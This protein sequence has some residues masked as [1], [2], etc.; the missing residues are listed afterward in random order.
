M[1]PQLIKKAY[2]GWEIKKYL[3]IMFLFLG[4]IYIFLKVNGLKYYKW[5]LFCFIFLSL[6]MEN[7][8]GT[9]FDDKID[10]LK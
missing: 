1:Y 3:C 5:C 8:F 6:A 9:I 7:I 10:E 4:N 2:F